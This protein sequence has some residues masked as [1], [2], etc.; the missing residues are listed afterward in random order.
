MKNLF[1]LRRNRFGKKNGFNLKRKKKIGFENGFKIIIP[2][3]K[4]KTCFKRNEKNKSFPRPV[5]NPYFH[6][7]Q[8]IN[9]I[10]I[11]RGTIFQH[12]WIPNILKTLIQYK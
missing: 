7:S 9:G 2:V 10:T 4:N 11:N 3:T 5:H 8:V 1:F 12:I 6:D